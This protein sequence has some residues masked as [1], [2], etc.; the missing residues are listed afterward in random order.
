MH[1]FFTAFLNNSTTIVIDTPP[2]LILVFPNSWAIEPF[3]LFLLCVNHLAW[4]IQPVGV[5]SFWPIT[6]ALP[7]SDNTLK[8]L[9]VKIVQCISHCAN[10]PFVPWGRWF[11]SHRGRWTCFIH[12]LVYSA[13]IT[14]VAFMNKFMFLGIILLMYKML[15]FRGGPSSFLFSV[16]EGH[17]FFPTYRGRVIAFYIRAYTFPPVTPLLKFRSVP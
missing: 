8:M 6:D 16:G 7:D 5:C 4:P 10:D 13:I 15:C 12:V 14:A 2:L 17:W 11:E 9:S 1:I 3:P